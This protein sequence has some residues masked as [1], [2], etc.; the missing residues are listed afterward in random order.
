ML[1]QLLTFLAFVVNRIVDPNCSH[2]AI[3]MASCWLKYI[4]PLLDFRLGHDLFWPV[5]MVVNLALTGL[6]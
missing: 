4:S 1:S 5:G 3:S 6:K 2:V